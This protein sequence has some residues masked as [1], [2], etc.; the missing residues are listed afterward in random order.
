MA[1]YG[2]QHSLPPHHLRKHGLFTE[3]FVGRFGPRFFSPLELA[4]AHG[5]SHQF[6]VPAKGCVG[7]QAVGNCIS[8]LGSVEKTG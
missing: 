8:G 5:I 1:M 6:V 4:I 7:H 2:N 3:L